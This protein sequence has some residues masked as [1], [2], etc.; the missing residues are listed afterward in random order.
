ME[1]QFFF[2]VILPAAHHAFQLPSS[3]SA[4]VQHK[5]LSSTDIV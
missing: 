2:W 1:I 5:T 3:Q 4:A